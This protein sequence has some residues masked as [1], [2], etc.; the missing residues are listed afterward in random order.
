MALNALFVITTVKSDLDLHDDNREEDIKAVMR[1]IQTISSESFDSKTAEPHINTGISAKSRTGAIHDE[2]FSDIELPRLIKDEESS[3][4]D[5]LLLGSLL[6]ETETKRSFTNPTE[7]SRKDNS[8]DER[9]NDASSKTRHDDESMGG[10]TYSLSSQSQSQDVIL[11]LKARMGDVDFEKELDPG[12]IDEISKLEH[13]TN[14]RAGF[15]SQDNVDNVFHNNYKEDYNKLKMNE[16]YQSHQYGHGM[17]HIYHLN[18]KPENVFQPNSNS[19]AKHPLHSLLRNRKL[20]YESSTYP[21]TIWEHNV[22]GT[23]NNIQ[24][25]YFIHNQLLPQRM[26]AKCPICNHQGYGS[27]K[28]D[29]NPLKPSSDEVKEVHSIE[30]N[31][32]I[33]ANGRSLEFEPIGTN[34]YPYIHE[35]KVDSEEVQRMQETLTQEIFR[36]STAVTETSRNIPSYQSHVAE[37]DSSS[38]TAKTYHQRINPVTLNRKFAVRTFVV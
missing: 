1:K 14:M 37:A 17:P 16:P 25:P 9:E 5:F 24:N 22:L 21:N 26:D 11:D 31:N 38:K 34:V 12:L 18:A 2:D 6:K 30:A 15:I 7:E 8:N 13:N 4:K 33:T 10:L 19:I 27:R 23:R 35:S 36:S 29:S 20:A 32:F 28:A 3:S